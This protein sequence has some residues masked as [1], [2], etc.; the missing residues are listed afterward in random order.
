M[1]TALIVAAVVLVLVAA[2]AGGFVWMCTASVRVTAL[3]VAA[4]V[5]SVAL[6][7]LLPLAINPITECEVTR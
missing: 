7:A 2:V 3:T 1:I 5:S 4:V 6:I